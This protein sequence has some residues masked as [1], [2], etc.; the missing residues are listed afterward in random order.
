MQC[1]LEASL[2]SCGPAAR[3]RTLG[4]WLTPYPLGLS[5]HPSAGDFDP[6]PH[7]DGRI[8]PADTRHIVSGR[9]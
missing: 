4:L 6:S 2:S 7:C 9:A 3:S 5:A 8:E 1:C